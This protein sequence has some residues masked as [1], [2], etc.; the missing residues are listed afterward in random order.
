MNSQNT[1]DDFDY[2]N[3]VLRSD[4]PDSAKLFFAELIARSAFRSLFGVGCN[5]WNSDLASLRSIK[6]LERA[7]FLV[8]TRDNDRIRYVAHRRCEKPL[9]AGIATSFRVDT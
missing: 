8:V 2:L 5:H 3:D 6:F 9:L 4:L 1:T 7:G